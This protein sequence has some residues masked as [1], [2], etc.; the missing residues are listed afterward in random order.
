M[1]K[2]Y[3]EANNIKVRFGR[4]V[5]L[6]DTADDRKRTAAGV[7]IWIKRKPGGEIQPMAQIPDGT[8][9]QYKHFRPIIESLTWV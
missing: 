4:E 1:T 2:K 9:E 8:L 3:P 7:V 6:L 5:V